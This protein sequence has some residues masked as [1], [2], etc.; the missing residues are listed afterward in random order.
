MEANLGRRCFLANTALLSLLPFAGCA[1]RMAGNEGD[2]AESRDLPFGLW[3]GVPGASFGSA[4]D[5]TAG[6]RRIHGPFAWTHPV[7]G[8]QL[9]VYERIN[10]EPDGVKR[11]LFTLR[12][13][14]AALARVFDSRPG[15]ADRAFVND[16]FFPLGPWRN[17]ERRSYPLTVHQA[18]STR[19][20]SAAIHVLEI[21]YT[22]DDVPNS[23]KYDWTLT[24]GSSQKLFHERFIYSPGIGFVKFSNRLT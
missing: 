19:R 14:G 13:D 9:Q 4:V 15:Q 12:P 20:Y 7:T 6:S 22:Y 11:Q 3:A 23:L 2:G 17:G 16:A 8:E 18:G 5:V 24:D 10:H 21:S 1:D